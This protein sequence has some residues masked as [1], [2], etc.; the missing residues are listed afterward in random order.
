M[1][2]HNRPSMTIEMGVLVLLKRPC[3]RS[4]DLSTTKLYLHPPVPGNS[5]AE[6]KGAGQPPLNTVMLVDMLFWYPQTE[7][8]TNKRKCTNKIRGVDAGSPKYFARFEAAPR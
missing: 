1:S 4:V 7:R 8:Q 3:P 2:W 6:K 5:A